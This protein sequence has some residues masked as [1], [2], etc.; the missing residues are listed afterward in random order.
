MTLRSRLVKLTLLSGMMLALFAAA[1]LA[2]GAEPRPF[3]GRVVATW[4][5]VFN[6][7]FAPPATFQGVSWV[8]HLGLA[9]Q[10]GCLVLGFPN[11]DGNF[12]GYGSVTMTAADG[13]QLTFDY[14]GVL[15]P[16]TGE[17]IGTLTFTGGTGRFANATGSGT[18]D[19]QIDVSQPTNQAMTV[20]LDG[21]VH[22]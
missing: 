17:G 4:D 7:L 10:E 14:E 9:E 18:F 21:E 2:Q 16:F 22:Y 13:H 5:N 3:S 20:L 8:T 11:A 12:P 6:A 15:N 19:A 1:P